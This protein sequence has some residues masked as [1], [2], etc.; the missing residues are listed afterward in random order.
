MARKVPQRKGTKSYMIRE[1]AERNLTKREA[2]AELRP[3]TENGIKP[4]V[5]SANVGGHRVPKSMADQ[6]IE[7]KNEIGRVYALLG[8]SVS[9]DFDSDEIEIPDVSDTEEIQEIDDVAVE[10]E[11]D[12]DGEE[13]D[14]VKPIA[15]GKKRIKDDLK[16]FLS[17]VR[18]IRK[19]CESRAETGA[20]IDWISIRPVQAAA[21]LIPS[22]IPAAALLHAM[23]MHWKPEIRREAGI[24]DFDFVRLS[25]T[26]MR[27]RGIDPA[28]K[29]KLFGYVLVLAE[30]RQPIMLIGP[31]GTGKSHLAHQISEYL[32]ITYGET[33]MTAGATRGDLL[34]RMTANPEQPFILSQFAEIYGSGGVF[35]FEEIDAADPGMLIVLNNALAGTR[36]YN[37]ANGQLYNRHEDFV[38]ISTAN[39]FGLGATKDYSG[40][41]RLDSAT[42][43]RWRMGRVF[44]PLDESVEE[45]MLYG[46]L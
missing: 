33:P 29:H 28:G 11:D 9:S 26:I 41:E 38:A 43:D 7:L 36:L 5:F 45:A 27:D 15:A 2:F 34:G 25:Q 1:L 24:S 30:N 14:D 17:E 16:F 12:D 10:E 40:R 32:G 31:A 6:L 42:I 20:A 21:K 13:D 23:T 18:R 46:N 8:R 39:T 3:L 22:G 19:L 44:V 4:M 37:S 35:N